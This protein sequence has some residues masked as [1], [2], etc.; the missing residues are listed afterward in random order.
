M[1]KPTDIQWFMIVL[2]SAGLLILLQT[3][4]KKGEAG[5]AT[6][7]SANPAETPAGQDEV[8]RQAIQESVPEALS[9]KPGDTE[10]LRKIYEE[11]LGL[12][13]KEVRK[14]PDG[15]FDATIQ[16]HQVAPVPVGPTLSATD[17]VRYSQQILQVDNQNKAVQISRKDQEQIARFRRGSLGL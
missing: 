4:S 11:K 7:S 1:K 12:V 6:L 15:T 14:N 2:A 13:L 5:H 8:V 16:G 10:G 3:L 17:Q 9:L